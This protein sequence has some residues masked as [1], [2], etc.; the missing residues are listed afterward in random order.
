MCASSSSGALHRR[1]SFF[2]IP[3]DTWCLSI[4]ILLSHVIPA[5]WAPT[6]RNGS[7]HG[8]ESSVCRC[9]GGRIDC[10]PEFTEVTSG[11]TS[12]HYYDHPLTKARPQSHFAAPH[13]LRPYAK[14]CALTHSVWSMY[15]A[16][17]LVPCAPPH[18][19]LIL[20]AN[21]RRL[22]I[23]T[24]PGTSSYPARH[25]T[26]THR[27][28]PVRRAHWMGGGQAEAETKSAGRTASEPP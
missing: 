1:T 18:V 19:L 14:T 27:F 24:L 12:Y 4:P 22:R 20:L 28:G 15:E 11:S 25:R 3:A 10:L 7:R 5:P 26:I 16:P 17:H 23:F 9:R 13:S 6:S 21:T 2:I 8:R